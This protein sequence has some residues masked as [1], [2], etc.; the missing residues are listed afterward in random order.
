[1]A[2]RARELKG[3]ARASNSIAQSTSS[4][5][6]LARPSLQFLASKIRGTAAEKSAALKGLFGG[7]CLSVANLTK[8]KEVDLRRTLTCHCQYWSLD[9]VD[10]SSGRQKANGS[11]PIKNSRLAVPCTLQNPVD[12]Y[13]AVKQYSDQ[14]LQLRSDP[15]MLHISGLGSLCLT[16]VWP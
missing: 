16:F 8:P 15:W 2:S 5:Y 7:D 6:S 13:S 12:G 1:M 4:R 11:W 14:M 10:E 3:A 9:A